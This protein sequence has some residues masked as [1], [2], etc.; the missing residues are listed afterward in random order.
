MSGMYERALAQQ[1]LDARRQRFRERQRV[2]LAVF[3]ATA[4]VF[5]AL[6]VR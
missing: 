4:V 3:C 6:F 5:F 2:L 1:R